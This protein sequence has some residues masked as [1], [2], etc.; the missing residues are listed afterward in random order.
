MIKQ[1]NMYFKHIT[2]TFIFFLIL[3]SNGFSQFK[4]VKGSTQNEVKTS[5][6]E[7]HPLWKSRKPANDVRDF[8]K[9]RFNPRSLSASDLIQLPE[10]F[11]VA[12]YDENNQPIAISGKLDE[13]TRSG[14]SLEEQSFTY[15]E[16]VGKVIGIINPWEE[17][18]LV[19]SNT[20]DLG[21]THLK[22]NQIF[23]GVE[24]LGA[25]VVT[26]SDRNVINYVNGNWHFR[27]KGINTN[28]SLSSEQAISKLNLANI[29]KNDEEEN[30]GIYSNMKPISKL[31]LL[32]QNETYKLVY[33][34]IAYPDLLHRWEYLV[35]AHTGE[36]VNQH[37]NSC[38]L[39]NHKFENSEL[40]SDFST[41]IKE[42]SNFNNQQ[43]F[44]LNIQPMADGHVVM[45]G[46]DLFGITR[47]VNSYEKTSL[48]YMIDANR[49][50]FK[51]TSTLPN[52]PTGAI[53]TIDAGNRKPVNQRYSYNH[54]STSSNLW[55]NPSAISAHFNGSK[56]YEYFK[57]TFGRNS[58]DGRGGTVISFINVADEDGSSMGNA[59]WNG[60]GLYY[61]NG[62]SGFF[63]LARALDVAGHEMAHGVIQNTANLNYEN[64]SGALNES[65]ADVFGSLIDRDDWKIGEDVVRL[66]EF[67]SGALRDLEDP[68]NRAPK[69]N[70]NKGYQPKVYSNRY[71]G[72]ED[73]GG[74]HI[75]SGIPNYA[76][77]LFAS[78]SQVGKD[79]AEKVYFRALST[80]LTRS[81]RFVDCRAAIIKS[82]QDL[83]GDAVAKIAENA[84]NSVE[85][86][87][88]TNTPPPTDTSKSKYEVDL[89]ENPGEDLIFLLNGNG[90][91]MD[92]INLKGEYVIPSP[93]SN[94]KPL[95][96][97]SITDDG[98]EIVYV[99]QDKKI[100]YIAVNY[101]TRTKE[102]VVLVDQAAFRNVIISRDGQR[103]AV[104]T[105][106]LQP[107]ILVFDS[108]KPLPR[109]FTLRN[110]TTASG[111]STGDVLYADAM[112]WD[113]SGEFII[114]DALNKV[115]GQGTTAISYWDISFMR[116]WSLTNKD[117][118]PNETTTFSK[119]IQNLPPGVDIGNPTFSKNSPY[120][121]AF[122]Y[123]DDEG[124]NNVLGA[125]I[126]N[127][128]IGL[129]AE[130]S[131]LGYPTYSK[132]D[133]FVLFD[134]VSLFNPTN[135]KIVVT[136]ASKIQ[137]AKPKGEVYIEDAKWANWFGNGF[138][139]TTDVKNEKSIPTIGYPN[140]ASEWISLTFEANK[141]QRSDFQLYS[142]DGRMLKSIENSI[143]AGTNTT[144]IDIKDIPKGVFIVK[145]V[146]DGK[147][148]SHQFIKI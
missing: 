115:E 1:I 53:W 78:N 121:I 12:H 129:L 128:N 106:D 104:L 75:N 71:K 38:K 118:M 62:D 138:R 92:I 141:N 103:I 26:H 39:H 7:V 27:P 90:V 63:P 52:N 70:Y 36:I 127:G 117:Y 140:P 85:V 126:E 61:G 119:L 82:S 60:Q 43:P 19:D 146:I 21:Q 37:M 99:G 2:L 68:N 10:G 14:K 98:S 16:K 125:N 41:S 48:R 102:E 116:A 114:Y 112:E 107:T 51:A 55:D 31:V 40:N 46:K 143:S 91:G 84:W 124:I 101:K 20:D 47:T 6:F 133:K 69:D 144:T 87:G 11:K 110:P 65:F 73:N 15:I 79:R 67:P 89:K 147:N 35:D 3:Q 24:I 142:I 59:F 123:Q 100:Y 94:R 23:N 34:I 139:I 4:V 33:Q 76:Y 135:I 95:S 83:Y 113:H 5:N 42:L 97:P 96:K 88:S 137:S 58:I 105:D 66:S 56:S 86:F 81:S 45:Q 50:M 8:T 54:I 30:F 148:L 57:N 17:L 122:D 44:Q 134:A 132:N 109:T 29:E 80:Y 64:E 130:S 93:L 28:A 49:D 120:I 9:V 32:P 145:T 72:T 22:F 25:E 111:V 18:K 136:D 108:S 13:K 77:F 131:D 74:V